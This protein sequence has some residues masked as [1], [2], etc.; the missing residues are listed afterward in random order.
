MVFF[1]S[2]QASSWAAFPASAAPRAKASVNASGALLWR[3]LDDMTRT[4]FMVIQRY[5]EA[6]SG[7]N[8]FVIFVSVC[9]EWTRFM[10]LLRLLRKHI[11]LRMVNVAG[12]VIF[13]SFLIR[14]R[15]KEIAIRKVNGATGW[16]IAR[17]LN[18]DFISYVCIA[19]LVAVPVSWAVL[20]A[21]QQRFAY[22]AGLDWW[23]FVLSGALVLIVSLLSVSLQSWKAACIN[24]ATGMRK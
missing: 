1:P 14:R 16:D 23:I 10:L 9:I 2:S 8:L 17:M 7:A 19:F 18:K 11:S 4:S 12:L 22:K 15:T 5:A 13:M 24:P 21:W 3:R 20:D 6:V